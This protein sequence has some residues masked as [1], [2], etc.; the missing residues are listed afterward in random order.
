[1]SAGI[2]AP[3]VDIAVAVEAGDWDGVLADA[4]DRATAACRAALAAAVLP[5]R[6]R[7]GALEL[8]IVLADDA[9]VQALNRD[10]RGKDRPTNVLSF[11]LTEGEEGPAPDPAVP[12][13]LG[14]V[15]LAL[16]TVAREAREQAKPFADHFSHLVVH[17]VLHLVGYDHVAEAEAEVMEAL[18]T[19]VLAGLG[20]ADP[21]RAG[22]GAPDEP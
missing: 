3:S 19:Q 5:P 1:M 14:D 9:V 21:Y 7:G 18:E 6:I 22:G 13:M 10:Y 12:V 17:G 11:A 4:P 2:S 20:I 16:E 15:I 8:G